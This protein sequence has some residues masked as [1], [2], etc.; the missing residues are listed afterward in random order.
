MIDN[1][2]MWY[3]HHSLLT[4]LL[5]ISMYTSPFFLDY[6][7]MFKP[8]YIFFRFFVTTFILKNHFCKISPWSTTPEKSNITYKRNKFFPIYWSPDISIMIYL[9]EKHHQT[10]ISPW[11]GYLILP[12]LIP[13]IVTTTISAPYYETYSHLTNPAPYINLLWLP[14]EKSRLIYLPI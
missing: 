12:L 5:H 7:P 2:L 3:I 14:Y 8:L 6:A 11:F 4:T 1:C 9:F 13:C 10:R